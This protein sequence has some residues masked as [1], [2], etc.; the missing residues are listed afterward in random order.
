[1]PA[2]DIV[3][4]IIEALSNP[5]IG[6]PTA[7]PTA[8]EV[9]ICNRFSETWHRM[10]FTAQCELL[11][12]VTRRLVLDIDGNTVQATFDLA[13]MHLTSISRGL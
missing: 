10:N 6:S 2:P 4:F 1:V 8:A 12:E 5:T 3:R 13:T 11:R 9:D 7:K